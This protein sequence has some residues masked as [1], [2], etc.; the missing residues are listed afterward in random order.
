MGTG[1]L[2]ARAVGLPR[3]GLTTTLPTGASAATAPTTT[4]TTM[5]STSGIPV[6]SATAPI[7]QPTPTRGYTPRG[8]AFR[9]YDDRAFSSLGSGL[10]TASGTDAQRSLFSGRSTSS[11]V[12]QSPQP[13]TSS[14][15]TTL[16]RRSPSFPGAFSS[17]TDPRRGDADVFLS[18]F[19]ARGDDDAPSR[20]LFTFS[21]EPRRTRG[22][23]FAPQVLT[24]P[25]ISDDDD[26]KE[27]EAPTIPTPVDDSK[28]G[29]LP[30][31]PAL[32]VDGAAPATEPVA[33][34]AE[35]AESEAPATG[36]STSTLTSQEPSS[37]SS[38][39]NV[40]QPRTRSG[41]PSAF[42][43]GSL[44]MM[45]APAESAT[46][47]YQRRLR[48]IKKLKF[49]H[50]TLGYTLRFFLHNLSAF[51]TRPEAE[52]FLN[53]CP[54]PSFTPTS[55][56][57]APLSNVTSPS[58][59][60]TKPLSPI[61]EKREV[62]LIEDCPRSGITIPPHTT[63]K[64]TGFALLFVAPIA[65]TSGSSKHQYGYESRHDAW[66]MSC[67]T[68]PTGKEFSWI[69]KAKLP[70]ILARDISTAMSL[71]PL[72]VSICEANA[73]AIQDTLIPNFSQKTLYS[74]SASLL[75]RA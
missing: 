7:V 3:P 13:S 30:S 68:F 45:V 38:L 39:R 51:M 10:G 8:G 67:N 58:N 26:E 64:T 5:P 59:E 66:R 27:M 48:E 20:N 4:T 57:S 46:E 14:G 50:V 32:G 16:F 70:R 24:G 31:T 69:M 17:P 29:A 72:Q 60:K 63:T 61:P 56:T 37:E 2:G 22:V 42:N 49:E 52:Y 34:A 11:F 15:S 36:A 73:F 55:Y 25:P 71:S 43:G 33:V 28:A 19:Q 41:A 53:A 62:I 74:Q 44:L 54:E 6:T 47:K 18:P 1:T 21:P 40:P 75:S 12:L 35:V 23:T 9:P 65:S